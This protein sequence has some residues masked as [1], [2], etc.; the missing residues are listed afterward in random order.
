[1][2]GTQ[3]A[4]SGRAIGLW[5]PCLFQMHRQH[6]HARSSRACERGR[7]R[8]HALLYSSTNISVVVGHATPERHVLR[9]AFNQ[10]ALAL[11]SSGQGVHHA[12]RSN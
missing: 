10:H 11:C 7:R 1:M 8:R 6:V 5:Y 3:C 9:F 12:A 4:H 2:Q